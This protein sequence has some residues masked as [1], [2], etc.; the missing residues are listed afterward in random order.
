M[1]AIS[2][3]TFVQAMK[4]LTFPNICE[5]SGAHVWMM[6][7]AFQCFNVGVKFM[8]PP[9][10]YNAIVLAEAFVL[11]ARV[12]PCAQRLFLRSCCSIE[13]AMATK[14]AFAPVRATHT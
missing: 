14:G 8:C 11:K 2:Q 1:L 13:A 5:T 9:Y 7:F 3:K 6:W 10:D 4:K 12:F